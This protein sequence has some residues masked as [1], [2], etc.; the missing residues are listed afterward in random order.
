MLNIVPLSE[1]HIDEIVKI[2]TECFSNPWSEKSFRGFLENPAA[3]CYTA[4]ENKESQESQENKTEVAGYLFSYHIIDEIQILNV[5]VE[6]SRRNSKIATKL[7]DVIFDYAKNN[8]VTEFTLEVRQ[9]NLAAI[10]LYKKLG[11][12]IDGVRKNYYAKPKEDAVLMSLR[13]LRSFGD[14]NFGG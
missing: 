1:E 14:L 10:G 4:T 9:S 3:V 6:K 11:F 7:F 2:E 8:K 12:K 5:A 13:D